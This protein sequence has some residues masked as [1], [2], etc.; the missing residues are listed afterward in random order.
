MAEENILLATKT[1]PH[2]REAAAR[3][4]AAGIPFTE[5]FADADPEGRRLAIDNHVSTVPVMFVNDGE[6]TK[7]LR[8]ESEII[9]FISEKK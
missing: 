4:T 3:L 9:A 5:L 2:C 6:G 7:M 8:N 1:C